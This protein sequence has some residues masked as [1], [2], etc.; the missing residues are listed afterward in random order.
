MLRLLAISPRRKIVGLVDLYQNCGTNLRIGSVMRES[1]SIIICLFEPG[2]FLA[3]Q[4]KALQAQQAPPE[5][6]WEVLYV[7]NTAQGKH[8]K[9]II[10]ASTEKVS[11]K[12]LHEPNPGKCRANNLAIGV[13]KGEVLLFTDEDVLPG[14]GW[15]HAMSWPILNGDADVV[16]ADIELPEELRRP[17]MGPIHKTIFMDRLGKDALLKAVLGSN[18]AI[19][20]DILLSIG[21]Y[22]PELGPGRLG[23]G[24][25]SLLGF[26][27]QRLACRF[28]FA[29]EEA[30]VL[31][32]VSKERFKRETFIRY[33]KLAAC[34]DA[35]IKYHW[36]H[37][38]EHL[39][40]L[41]ALK[42]LI[43]LWWVRAT[44]KYKCSEGIL[45]NEHYQI[46]RIWYLRQFNKEQRRQHNYLEPGCIKVHGELPQLGYK[47]TE[48]TMQA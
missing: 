6:Q 11:I 27:L 25:D 37:K 30:T 22:D 39:A 21:G 20:R 41:K 45:P 33:A 13:A 32:C 4:I 40:W 31:H 1:V 9:T 19:K 10:E 7:D 26:Q 2:D 46:S 14:K 3:R 15:V 43:G 12:Y 35:Y 5:L 34:S 29:G 24:E 38:S 17:W 36:N 16:N 44:R 42:S 8:K 47:E 28:F 18:A 48:G 23:A